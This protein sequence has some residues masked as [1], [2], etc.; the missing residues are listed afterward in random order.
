MNS[1][2]FYA[3]EWNEAHG[4]V[5]LLLFFPAIFVNDVIHSPVLVNSP[6]NKER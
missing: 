3:N 2:D 1:I 4:N 5:C 6:K